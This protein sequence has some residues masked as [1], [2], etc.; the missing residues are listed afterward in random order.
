MPGTVEL[1]GTAYGH[2]ADRAT[3][4]V[5]R[6][7]YGDD[8][9]QSSWVTAD[10]YRRFIARLGLTSADHVLDM[11]S[12]SGGP[13]LF[14]A[15]EAG[16]R[17]TGV[18]VDPAGLENARRLVESAGLGDR[19]AFQRADAGEPL[20]FDAGAFDAVVCLDAVCHMPDRA[21]LFAEWS[22][23]LRPGGRVLVTDPVVVVGPVSKEEFATRSSTGPFEFCA[24][25][26]NERLLDAAGF[27]TVHVEDGTTNEAEVSRRWHDA[28]QA[29]RADLERI[30]GAETFAGLQ[31][32]LDV[33][34]RLT[35][36]RR[37][38]RLVYA[39]FKPSPDL[40][41]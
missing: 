29:H 40:T 33:V 15:R 24:G 23:V 8:F 22:R 14:L 39:A 16:C 1:Y 5:R 20:P 3:A 6:A 21:R 2:F 32:F 30:E 34:H 25:G 35:R 9:G 7:T 19:V 18:D 36:D 31:R 11:G 17:V 27:A 10:E 26:V 12:G 41:P 28:R 38:I 13:A 37:L 4:E